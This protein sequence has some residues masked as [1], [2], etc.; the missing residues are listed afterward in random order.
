[1]GSAFL[2][3]GA[4]QIVRAFAA[5]RINPGCRRADQ[6]PIRIERAQ[7][8]RLVGPHVGLN[9][10]QRILGDEECSLHGAV[11]SPETHRAPCRIEG[12]ALIGKTQRHR[13]VRAFLIAAVDRAIDHGDATRG[14]LVRYSRRS[15]TYLLYASTTAATP[16]QAAAASAKLNR[17]IH[18]SRSSCL[19]AGARPVSLPPAPGALRPVM[20]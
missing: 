2:E 16:K 15:A 3:V 8:P 20:A 14:A 6:V 17:V 4:H 12:A 18:T 7:Q 11:V 9:A 19:Q 10:L 13:C 1:N 5:A